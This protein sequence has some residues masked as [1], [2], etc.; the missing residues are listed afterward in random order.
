LNGAFVVSGSGGTNGDV[1]V[2]NGSTLYYTGSLPSGVIPE[3][4][5][6]EDD[7]AVNLSGNLTV[8]NTLITF[9]STNVTI[10]S[11]NLNVASNTTISGN[12]SVA[13]IASTQNVTTFGTTLYVTTGGNVGISNSAPTHKLR[14]DGTTSLAGA[15]T[16]IT[17]LAGGNTTITGFA[18]VSVSVNSA[19]LT[20]GSSFIANTTGAYHTGI[21]NSVSFT[22]G[23]STIANSTGV[24][25]GVVNGSSITVGTS[26]IANSTG[27]YTGVVN[28]TSVNAASHTVGTSTIA[29]S[30]GVYTGV[31]NATSVNAASH[32]VGTNTIANST[33]VYTGV[34]NAT[35]VNSSAFTVGSTFIANATNVGI[36]TNSP[37]T[38]LDV[39]GTVSIAKANVLSQTL[40]DAATIS[41]DTSLGQVATVTLGGNRTMAAPTNIKIGTYILHVIQDGSG[42]RTL[43]WNS[44]FKWPAGVAPTLTTT[45]S[46]RDLFSF[47][48]D[49]TNLYGSFLP[50]VR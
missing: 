16:D 6:R 17:T 30:T 25:T 37:A 34:V 50:D 5:V 39:S 28:A 38:T 21:I 35:S 4:Y 13:R 20:V 14:V 40:S 24:Y 36:G 43:S 31:V 18:N 19:A 29:N 1:L 3:I 33:G 8:N 10:N 47:V 15:V 7:A 46:R 12:L 22:V 2:C 44:V 26:T 41:W 11:T 9:N 27:V 48:C 32:T 45:A 23:T 49:G 42:N